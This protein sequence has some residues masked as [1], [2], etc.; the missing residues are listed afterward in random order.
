M[1]RKNFSRN[2]EQFLEQD[3]GADHAW[4]P[5]KGQCAELTTTQ[6]TYKICIFDRT[7][8]KDRSGHNEVDLGYIFLL[9]LLIYFFF[10]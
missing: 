8:Q 3:Y 1:K 7:I 9:F 5:L 6:Y 10:F 4:A 2:S